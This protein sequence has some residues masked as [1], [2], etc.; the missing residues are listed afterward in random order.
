MKNSDPNMTGQVHDSSGCVF[1]DLNIPCQNPGCT[2]CN[3][4]KTEIAAEAIEAAE[5]IVNARITIGDV[6]TGAQC[7][8]LIFDIAFALENPN[9]EWTREEWEAT[10]AGQ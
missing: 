1:K 9:Y 7:R 3:P 6:I 10:R 5:K 8:D 2:V 4:Q